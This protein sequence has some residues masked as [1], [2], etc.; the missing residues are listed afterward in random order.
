MNQS[1]IYGHPE[2]QC[3]LPHRYPFLFLD[4]VEIV[5]G[6]KTVKGL[7]NFTINE[8]IFQGHFPGEPL[9]PGVILVECMAQTGGFL[10]ITK[11]KF[12]RSYLSSIKECK[13]LAS[14]HP[15]DQLVCE[16]NYQRKIGDFYCA[17]G[18]GYVNKKRVIA[19]NL[20][21]VFINNQKAVI[22]EK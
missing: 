15:G 20:A 4:K 17:T 7:K 5:S 8:N 1:I 3:Y 16:M 13:F 10:F 9:V 19:I 11:D 12:K 21:Y 6:E 2:I 18:I 22:N 14:V